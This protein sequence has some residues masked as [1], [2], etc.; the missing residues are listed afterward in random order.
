LRNKAAQRRVLIVAQ[1]D[2]KIGSLKIEK[3]STRYLVLGRLAQ[4]IEWPD[5]AFACC[6]LLMRKIAFGALVRS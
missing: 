5:W 1:G 6:W 3:E 4:E 2:S